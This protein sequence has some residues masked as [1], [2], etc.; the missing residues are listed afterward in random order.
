MDEM[1]IGESVQIM[2]GAIVQTG[3]VIGDNVIINASAMLDQ[4]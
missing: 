1:R 3:C 2:A 4:D